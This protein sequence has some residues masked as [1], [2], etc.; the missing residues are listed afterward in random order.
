[1]YFIV[2]AGP[3]RRASRDYWRRLTGAPARWRDVYRQYHTFAATLLDR[4]DLVAG[5]LDRFD[6]RTSGGDAVLGALATGRG[7][8]L[9]GA[10]FG[11][12]EVM[13]AV[14]TLGRGIVLNVVMHEGNAS[15]IG[16]WMRERAPSL[17][18][19]TI[20]SGRAETML[21]VRDCL[22]RGEAVALL[23]DRPFADAATVTAPFL[24]APVRLPEGPFR[25]AAI[26][27]VPTFLFFGI[28]RGDRRYELRF[29]PLGTDARLHGR[30]AAHS[31]ARHY[32]ARLEAQVRDAPTNWFN[33]YDYWSAR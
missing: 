27:G 25:L 24:G 8:L 12:F 22:A 1:M 7:C 17:A 5:Q 26:L 29:E 31:L 28:H 32:A 33:F 21:R 30:E 11:S 4:I 16:A 18:L 6:L 10:H 13:R 23:A 2:F 3:A 19:R 9:L 20:P 15:L 14:G